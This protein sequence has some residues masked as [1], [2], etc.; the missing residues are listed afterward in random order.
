MDGHN[1]YISWQ[2]AM[3]LH[4]YD[5]FTKDVWLHPMTTGNCNCMYVSD[6]KGDYGY[7]HVLLN[8]LGEHS[9]SVSDKNGTP[10]IFT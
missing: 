6:K 5:L 1:L 3:Q 10:A 9:C 8:E 4:Y 7:I 2:Y